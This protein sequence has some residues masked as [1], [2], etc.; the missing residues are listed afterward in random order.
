MGSLLFQSLG[1]SERVC[2]KG[3]V[4][5]QVKSRLR[6][7]ATNVPTEALL[8]PTGIENKESSGSLAGMNE[9]VARLID[10]HEETDPSIRSSR[11]LPERATS[12]R[13]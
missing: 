13:R 8:I 7:I 3:G 6:L 10:G 1:F 9:D 12:S 11:T 4:A 5:S 2:R